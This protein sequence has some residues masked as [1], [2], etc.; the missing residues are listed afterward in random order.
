MMKKNRM[1]IPLKQYWDLLSRHIRPQKGRFALLIFIM[2]GNIGLQ[3]VNPQIM[4][5]FIDTALGGGASKTLILA[6]S[7]F[8]GIALAQQVV[9]V[10]VTYLGESV[11]WTATNALRA[12]LAWHCLNLDM[13]FH[14]NH[15]PGE[16]I[17]RIDGDVTEMSN[18][19][20]QF[21]VQL[22]SNALLMVGILAAL[23]REDWRTGLAF[24]AFAAAS[25][26]ILNRVRDLAVPH[27][28]ARRQAEAELFGFI[29]EQLTGTEDIRSSGAVEFSLRELV[30]FQGKILGHAR[31]AE[32]ISWGIGSI[33]DSTVVAGTL[34]AVGAGYL[35]F[36]G[37]LVTLGT[38]YLFVYYMNMIEGPIF[39][40]TRQ[41]QDFQTIGACV[42]RL[43]EL[44][45]IENRVLDSA[46]D[47]K[48]SLDG[49]G[50]QRQA[51]QPL[52]VA[53][54][55][56][57]FAYGEAETVLHDLTFELKPG[58]VLGLLGR[59]GSGKTTL[60]RLIF[61][62]YDPCAGQIRINGQ[63]LRDIGLQD[64]RSQVAMVTQDV[65]LFRAS[66]RDNLTFFDRTISDEQVLSVI[67]E[68]GLSS[69]YRS[70]PEGLDTLID[71]GGHSLSAGEAQLLAFV[72]VFLR[73]PGLVILDEA[74]SR[75]DPATE[76]HIE[77][78]IDR[79]LENRTAII[80]AHRLGTVH[81]ADEI[82][83]LEDGRVSE[84]GP[85]AALA[86]DPNSRFYSLLQT[87]L[88]EVLA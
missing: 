1:N 62:L 58:R 48:G 54:N 16:L 25:V 47:G 81:R 61:R 73:N 42:E 53:F 87:G 86:A 41:I 46:S 31:K 4:R 88:E 38:A 12:E 22:A 39:A 60:T 78:A 49:H 80:V 13:S 36:Q 59:T 79:L 40:M 66:V 17:E 76:Q 11:A 37:G 55:G 51:S 84:H 72:R 7:A 45:K 10:S 5:S 15:T 34:L 27:Q 67:D 33:T 56:V 21:V 8:I 19:F 44:R 52:A 82:M 64:L 75:L 63:D 74:S 32:K 28:K 23:F 3:V 85:R 6:A 70:L 26:Y 57:A 20:S 65:Q 29:E 9:A 77:R 2:L 43:T 35:L 68:L 14:N 30:R 18:F 50:E 71:T 69:W 83:I 24:T